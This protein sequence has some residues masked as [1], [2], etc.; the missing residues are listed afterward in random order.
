MYNADEL[1]KKRKELTDELDRLDSAYKEKAESKKKKPLELERLSYD[2]PSDDELM[3]RARESV[4]KK[5]GKKKE[6]AKTESEEKAF[7]FENAVKKLEKEREEGLK[8]T[9]EAYDAAER[10]I[11]AD[12][13]KRGVQRSSIASNRIA[14]AETG[15]LRDKTEIEVKS[16]E[17]G[18]ELKEKI[19][20]LGAE[21]E[22]TL[23]EV[24]EAGSHEKSETYEKLKAER[25][26]KADEVKKYNNRIEE[27]E[28]KYND[29]IAKELENDEEANK[30]KRNYDVKKAGA[31]LDYYEAFEDKQAALDDFLSEPKF[32][33]YLG[34]YYAYVFS[35]LRRRA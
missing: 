11:N 8:K 22:K 4:E 32:E 28:K 10:K 30:V 27:K 6:E 26:E 12:V 5:Y 33:D 17:R 21:L 29:S 7:S 23:K 14:E 18:N 16:T 35:I 3:E 13:V 2:A 9:D 25:D 31:V 20:T 34:D 1:K 24:E 19:R 15:R